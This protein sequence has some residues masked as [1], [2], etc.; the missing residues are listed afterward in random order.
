MINCSNLINYCLAYN[1]EFH[2]FFPSQ[3]IASVTKIGENEMDTVCSK[4]EN[5]R[6]CK[7]MYSENVKVRYGVRD[8]EVDGKVILKWI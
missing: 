7:E 3:N 6:M 2:I 4:H 5:T 1:E 8:L